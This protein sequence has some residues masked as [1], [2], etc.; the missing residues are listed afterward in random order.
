MP[1]V[2]KKSRGWIFVINNY[3]SEDVSCVQIFA[4]KCVYLVY[5]LEIGDSGTPHIQGYLYFK[6]G[7]AF[8]RV[9]KQFPTAHI[10]AARGDALTNRAYCIKD[11][12]WFEYGVIPAQG[13]RTDIES[14]VLKV[15]YADEKIGELDLL[16]D[17]STM[18]CRYPQFVDRVQRYFHP[19]T[20]LPVKNNFWYY[21]PTDTG[22]TVRAKELGTY[23]VKAPNKW[24]CGYTSEDVLIVEDVGPEHAS[25]LKY[26][27][28]MWADHSPFT[29]QTKGSSI[30][31]R[32]K[33]I[34]VTSNYSIDQMGWDAVTTEAMKSRFGTVK[35]FLDFYVYPKDCEEPSITSSLL[36]Q[37]SD[38]KFGESCLPEC[39]SKK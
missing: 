34:V 3:T 22:K 33:I 30:Y 1:K 15:Q 18:V 36:V 6:S 38:P 21:G 23:F 7:S 32:P 2:Y 9:K 31:I 4:E 29:A 8:S 20:S 24:F 12:S 26:A 14:F 28:K 25:F 39:P 16:L 27:L 17:H 13:A 37:T 35:N 11:G 5:G 10:E 19:P